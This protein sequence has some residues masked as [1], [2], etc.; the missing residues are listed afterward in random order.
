MVFR[1]SLVYLLTLT[2]LTGTPKKWETRLKE[3]CNLGYSLYQPVC[4]HGNSLWQCCILCVGDVESTEPTKSLMRIAE[5]I[6]THE[7]REELRAW[8]LTRKEE[9]LDMLSREEGRVTR[10]RGRSLESWWVWLGEL[11]AS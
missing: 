8:F 5:Y 3:R 11:R 7:R 2:V 4:F 9:V 6:D 1:Y 10:D